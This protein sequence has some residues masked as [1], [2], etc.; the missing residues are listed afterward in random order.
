MH[1]LIISLALISL[2]F[3]R[4]HPLSEFDA[5]KRSCRRRLAGHNRRRRKTQPEDVTPQ[6]SV[7]GGAYNN[8]NCN[9]DVINL[10]SVLRAQGIANK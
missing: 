2:Y 6:A 9:L 7:P 3:N 10:L 8:S 5:G 4:F 1:I